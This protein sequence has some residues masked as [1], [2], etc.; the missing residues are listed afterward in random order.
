MI[1]LT[2]TDYSQSSQCAQQPHL[3]VTS[4]EPLLNLRRVPCNTLWEIMQIWRGEAPFW[5]A[6]RGEAHLSLTVNGSIR[7]LL[8]LRSWYQSNSLFIMDINEQLSQPRPWIALGSCVRKYIYTP[9]GQKYVHPPRSPIPWGPKDVWY[10]LLSCVSNPIVCDTLCWV[11][12]LILSCVIPSIEPQYPILLCEIQSQGCTQ[13]YIPHH[14]LQRSSTA[15][16]EHT[17]RLFWI[18]LFAVSCIMDVLLIR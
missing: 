8:D 4:R 3:G 15:L 1:F 7:R 6:G 17:L 18:F 10:C 12:Y 14:L 11:V 13:H 9:C 2:K 5:R 16:L